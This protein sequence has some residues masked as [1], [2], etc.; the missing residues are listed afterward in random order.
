MRDLVEREGLAHRIEIESAGTGS[1]H[2]GEPADERAQRAAA[3]RGY[4]LDRRARQFTRELF[5]RYDYVLAMD[6]T[7]LS[8]LLEI[9]PSE[10]ARQRLFLLRSF[11]AQSLD[12]AEVPDPYYGGPLGFEHVL[13]ICETACR[14]LLAEL[15]R[16]HSL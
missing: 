15:R 5:A 9:A 10:A 11:D 8:N 14:G 12:T 1:W 16:R 4:A 3:L 7:N 13:D 6:R 2:V